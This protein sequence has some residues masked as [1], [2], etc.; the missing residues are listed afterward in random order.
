MTATSASIRFG[1]NGAG[2]PGAAARWPGGDGMTETSA[3]I[4]FSAD[5][6]AKVQS[7]VRL[8]DSTYIRCCTYRRR[9]RRS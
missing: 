2:G 8:T 6:T 1:A 9:T 4:R 5:G 7:Y 3:S